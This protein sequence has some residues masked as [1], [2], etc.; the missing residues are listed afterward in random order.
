MNRKD[1]IAR[2]IADKRK[3]MQELNALT[4]KEERA[5]SK[6]E[7]AEFDQLKEEIRDLQAELEDLEEARQEETPVE[8]FNIKKDKKRRYNLAKAIRQ[9]AEGKLDGVEAECHQEGLKRF[10]AQAGSQPTKVIIPDEMLSKRKREERAQLISNSGGLISEIAEGLDI[11]HDGSFYQTMGTTVFPNV[12]NVMKLSF[13]APIKTDKL[14][15][16]ASASV[17]DHTK[18]TQ[19]LSPNRFS[20]QM[21]VSRENMAVNAYVEDMVAD[22][23]FAV[24]HG[25]TIDLLAAILADAGVVVSGFGTGAATAA[26][27]WQKVNALKRSLVKISRFRKPGYLAG[28]AVFGELET[29]IKGGSGSGRFILEDDKIGGSPI[30][31]VENALDVHDTDKY[32][33]LYGDWARSYVAEFG[34]ALEIITDPYTLADSGEIKITFVRL[35]DVAYNPNAFAAYRNVAVS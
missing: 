11:L 18:V 4:E 35:A 29:I 9:A 19:D 1:K 34:G 17:K 5:K 2:D 26:V 31:N 30:V 7:R 27:D 13:A 10:G 28:S 6:E 21:Q 12:Q 33:L 25:I 22:G 3:R 14:A 24:G 15:E 32:D 23:N 16:Q 8:D 20:H